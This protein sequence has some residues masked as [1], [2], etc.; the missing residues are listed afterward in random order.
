[1]NAN[2]P[3]AGF[4]VPVTV[5]DPGPDGRVGTSDDGPPIAAWNLSS[6]YLGLPVR[7]VLTNVPDAR[8][9]FYTW[10]VTATKRMN[11]GWSAVASLSHTIS[12]AQANVLFDTNFRQNQLPI[13][14]NDLINTA[15]DGQEQ[16]TD[17]AAKLTASWEGPFGLK[18]SPVYRFQSGQNFGRTI[19]AS[20]NYGNI[21]IPAEPLN[22]R[23][24]DNVSL[25][26]LRF[27]RA[28]RIRNTRVSPF[29]DIY[30]L[31]N[32]NPIQNTSWS[33]GSSFLRPLAIVPPRVWR[34]GAKFDW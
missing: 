19:V 15:P 3:F 34:A 32:A 10:E 23:R 22:A 2:Q 5:P 13:T 28:T 16:S 1:L 12:Y 27:E 7:N 8:T 24:Q 29:V 20:L 26:D 30:N 6:Q 4:T 14:P 17:T 18:I 25:I 11:R 9:N 33:S 21:R 31:T